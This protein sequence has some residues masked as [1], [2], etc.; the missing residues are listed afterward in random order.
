[1]KAIW[2]GAISFGLV[3]IPVKMFSASHSHSFDLDM[4]RKG[5]HCK[6]K[7][8]RVCE[9]DGKEIP[10]R[11]IVKGYKYN[12]GD[13][14]ILTDKDF[15][16]A[17]VEKSHTI[18]L[19]HFVN[20]NE[21]NSVYYEKPY[22]LEPEKSGT[23]PYALLREAIKN[24]KK[25]GVAKFVMKNREHIGV[26]KLYEDAI[27]LNQLRYADEVRKTSDLTLPSSKNIS[28]KEV[29]MATSLIKQLT[30]KFNPK[31]YKDT[32]ID[33]LK[34]IIE[35]KAKGKRIKPAGKA[36]KPTDTKS[37][38]TLLKKSIAKKAA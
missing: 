4:L 9:D 26:L 24:S 12:G 19:L 8:M 16:N 10:F 13:Y 1:M 20:E 29:E 33:D 31:D 21:V 11:D 17:N 14:V 36:P 22:Y 27:V 32:Y 5:D 2:K 28:E 30:H 7:Y 38:M 35:Q 37:L 3:N 15:E 34:K 25:V 6:V 23:K 18:D